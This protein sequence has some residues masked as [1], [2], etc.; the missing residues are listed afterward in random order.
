[1]TAALLLKNGKYVED[2]HVLSGFRMHIQE[3]DNPV[4]HPGAENLKILIEK[5]T[6]YSEIELVMSNKREKKIQRGMTASR[7]L[8]ES[9][10]KESEKTPL[11]TK[12][13]DYLREEIEKVNAN[14][15]AASN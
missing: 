10:K 2:W 7:R 1:M 11:D 14:I 3:G 8:I 15:N 6:D 13:I 9:L 12:K 4:K 5:A